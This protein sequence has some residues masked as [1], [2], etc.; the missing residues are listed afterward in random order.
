MK[1]T[2]LHA[3]H[4]AQGAKMVDLLYHMPMVYSSV[5]EEHL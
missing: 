3:I 1:T 5:K 4:V 2:A